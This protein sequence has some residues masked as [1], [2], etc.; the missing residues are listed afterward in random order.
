MN[1]I[2]QSGKIHV[3]ENFNDQEHSREIESFRF[4]GPDNKEGK[5]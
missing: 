3:R 2:P 5:H 1:F 4:K